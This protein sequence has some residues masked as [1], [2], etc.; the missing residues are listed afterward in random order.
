[1]RSVISA[2]VC[3]MSVFA[4]SADVACAIDGGPAQS[5]TTLL[6]PWH[7]QRN[8]YIVQAGTTKSAT[9]GVNF[10]P[11]IAERTE[12]AGVMTPSP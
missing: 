6:N 2:C 5:A 7:Q 11:S 9:P 1:M 8:Q 10:S 12:I 3:V 4:L